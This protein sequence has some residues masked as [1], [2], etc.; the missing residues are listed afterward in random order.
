MEDQP[1]GAVLKE[2]RSLAMAAESSADARVRKEN[3]KVER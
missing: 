1:L 3:M 2:A